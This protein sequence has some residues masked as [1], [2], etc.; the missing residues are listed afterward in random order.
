[1]CL[2]DALINNNL[3]QQIA[4]SP[5]LAEV[6]SHHYFLLDSLTNDDVFEDVG[7]IVR[8]GGHRGSETER[9]SVILS[10]WHGFSLEAS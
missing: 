7:V 8:G 6:H 5:I 9:G 1:M 2:G 4:S 3:L 10:E